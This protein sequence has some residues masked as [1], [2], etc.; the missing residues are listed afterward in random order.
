M[1]L[2]ANWIKQDIDSTGTGTLD[3]GTSDTGFIGFG[4]QFTDGD[5]VSYTITDGNDRET[6]FGVFTSG[7]PDTL[8][9]ARIEA[10][11]ISGTLNKLT[12]AALT[13]TSAAI[14]ES[15]PT[16]HNVPQNALKTYATGDK[17]IDAYMSKV[18]VNQV[19]VADE[20]YV[21]PFYLTQSVVLDGLVIRRLEVAATSTSLG[22]FGI[23]RQRI[24]GLPGSVIVEG[25][26]TLDMEVTGFNVGVSFA[27]TKLQ[28]GMYYVAILTDGDATVD[29][30]ASN[31]ISHPY[32]CE[33]NNSYPAQSYTY[34]ITPGWS[35][36]PDV[37]SVTPAEGVN[38]SVKIF[39][40]AA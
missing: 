15:P 5:V 12:A 22:R 27:D 32:M 8:T 11:L 33:G 35:A 14:V 26:G 38:E 28:P 37:T 31:D 36:M 40:N 6:G 29:A 20:M 10:T 17:V 25:T 9:R 7:T 24:D 23:Y 13:L 4:D 2:L 34:A 3:L 39:G 30:Q 16:T 18:D 21:Q 1:S 19:F